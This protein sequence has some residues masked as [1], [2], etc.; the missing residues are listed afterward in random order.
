MGFEKMADSMLS[1]A[2]NPLENQTD[3]RED[4]ERSIDREERLLTV[5]MHEMQD[6]SRQIEEKQARGEATESD[7]AKLREA[8][9]HFRDA[10]EPF[11]LFAFMSPINAQLIMSAKIENILIAALIGATTLGMI[12]NKNNVQQEDLNQEPA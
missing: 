1:G 12:L 5:Q 9:I 2:E 8:F 3:G 4:I 7:M 10:I 6:L 11:L